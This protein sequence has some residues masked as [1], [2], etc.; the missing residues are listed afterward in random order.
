MALRKGKT[1]ERTTNTDKAARADISS[2]HASAGYN[3]GTLLLERALITPEQLDAAVAKE[4][5]GKSVGDALV[6]MGAVSERDMV[7]A[8]G[9]RLEVAFIDLRRETPA[10]DAVALL[11][12]GL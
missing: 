11:P 5:E 12:E 8:L 6:D 10:P 3:V 9:E 4:T 1:T 7:V 2:A